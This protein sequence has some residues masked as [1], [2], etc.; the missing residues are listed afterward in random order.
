MTIVMAR[1]I[2]YPFL[3]LCVWTLTHTVYRLR[4]INKDVIPH[5]GGALIVANHLSFVDVLF[6]IVSTSR[7]VRFV[8]HRDVYNVWWLRPLCRIAGAIPVSPKDPPKEI[9]RSLEFAREA[10]LQ[11]DVVCIF[12][13]GQLSRTGNTL[14]FGR[15]V[16]HVM[17]GITAP[18]IPAY[19]DRTWGS[20]FSFEGGRFFLKLPKVVPHPITI[21]FGQP[22]SPE[23]TSFDIRQAVLELGS[24]A[25]RFRL[26]DK[27]TLSEMFF[28]EIRY[29][30]LRFCVA[31]PSGKR[32]NRFQT[33]L[34]SYALARKLKTLTGNDKFVGILLPPSVGGAVVNVAL[35]ILGKVAVN[36]NYTASREAMAHA[37]KECGMTRCLTARKF[38]EKLQ[39]EAPCEPVFVE[40]LLK[41]LT[42]LDW[43]AALGPIVIFPRAI[44]HRIIF[45]S[46]KNRDNNAL[47]T[48]VFT[49]G[50]TGIPKGVM[51]THA[52]ISS[53]L[54]GLYQVFGIRRSDVIMGVLPFFHSF[55]YTAGLWFP[56]VGGMGAA[57]HVNPLD[58]KVVGQMVKN[59]RAT[60]LLATPTFLS[61]YTRRCEKEEFVSLRVVVVG[62]EKLKSSIG[63]AFLDKFGL[64]ALEGY[65]CTELSPV[66]SLNLPDREVAEGVQKAQKSGSIGMPLPG[67][68]VR[69]V[70][71]ETLEPRGAGEQGL[72]LVRGGNV[73]QGYLNQPQKT[74]EAIVD[75]WYCTGDIAFLDED[76]FITI[77]DRL[78]RFSK[79]GG[80]MVPHVKVEEAIHAALGAA[81]QVCI[82]TSVP[83]EKKGE[84]LVVLYV[85]E[86]NVDDV[87]VKIKAAGLPN[88]WIP[89]TAMFIKIDAIPLLGSG[90]L[91]LGAV[92][93]LAAEKAG[94]RIK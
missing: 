27:M 13:E 42:K 22:L 41:G 28:N 87:C 6:I 83:D 37:V 30:P 9:L 16:E 49:S 68:A 58:A 25:F 81:E 29:A 92:K 19:L 43:L 38:L 48:I 61:A 11:G 5:A 18:V 54:E 36:L 76:G 67:I 2:P 23:S 8:T 79:I 88:L 69:I 85:G 74:A 52:N 7:R 45:G 24:G 73:M 70:D 32:L 63:Q 94:G 59:Y 71:P 46:W 93:K 86:M 75:G 3:R 66:V 31:D 55:G 53:N 4:V 51:L 14:R 26:E 62:A 72:L 12:P 77:T 15:G 20:I 84:K 89:D 33:F 21:I 91:D 35:D 78:S 40:D 47:A 17:K 1:V 82:V 44:A 39:I 90:K 80:E 56:L 65:G 50:S 34:V 57:Y 64:P 60:I 10:I